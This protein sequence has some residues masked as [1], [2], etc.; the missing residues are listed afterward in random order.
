[1]PG[2]LSKDRL[3]EADKMVWDSYW[4][5]V[6]HRWELG[7]LDGATVSLEGWSRTL[8]LCGCNDESTAQL[9]RRTHHQFELEVYRLFS[10]VR[11]LIGSLRNDR[12]RMA[13]ITNGASD[14]QRDKLR[15]LE[16]EHWFDCVVVSGELGV[17]KPDARI[18]REALGKLAIDGEDVWHVGDNLATDV[19]GA[20]AAEIHSVW[21]NRNGTTRRIGD[22]EPDIEVHSLADKENSRQQ[23]IQGLPKPVA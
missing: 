22:P 18:F 17:A 2:M 23:N 6:E 13:L 21:L 16:M 15:V 11:D 8:R 4:P 9:A 1:M 14:T 10:E 20:R 3:I 7:V 19:G 5:D 12:V